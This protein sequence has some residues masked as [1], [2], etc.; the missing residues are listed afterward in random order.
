MN[1]IFDIETNGFLSDVTKIHCIV[2]KDI[3]SKKVLSF[4][5]DN[6]DNA[7]KIISDANLLVGHNVQKYDLPVIKKLY[8]DFTYKGKV[9]DTLLVSRLIWTNQKE[10][11]FRRKEVPLKLAGRHSLESWG[12]R[13]GLR[14]G[15]FIK[16]GDFSTWS[17]EMQDYCEKDVEVTFELYKLIQKQNYS[18]LAIELEHNFAEL[19]I[20]QEAHG[21]HFDVASAK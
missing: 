10:E 1:I 18:P 7:I 5:Y 3:D 8:P 21:F 11:D 2:I 20:R 14:K 13:L 12:Y 16:T 4:K 9:F 17:Q 15:D 6:I 19:I